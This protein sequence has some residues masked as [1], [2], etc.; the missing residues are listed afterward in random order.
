MA[1]E[2]RRRIDALAPGGGYVVASVHIVQA[3]V[4]PENVVAMVRTAQEYGR[5]PLPR[6]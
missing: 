6:G 1:A 3:E 4:A 2:V 5:Y